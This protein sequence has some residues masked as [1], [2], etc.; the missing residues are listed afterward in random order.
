MKVRHFEVLWCHLDSRL[1]AVN[2][3]IVSP[4]IFSWL[5]MLWNVF[6]AKTI[7]ERINHNPFWSML[8]TLDG[9]VELL[10]PPSK[11]KSIYFKI[12]KIKM[13]PVNTYSSSFRSAALLGRCFQ[14]WTAYFDFC[15][16]YDK[17]MLSSSILTDTPTSV[18]ST[19]IY[20]P[21]WNFGAFS[22]L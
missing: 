20:F 5:K 4:L 13:K 3:S 18:F 17:S 21:D 7:T 9:A 14:Y 22:W 15:C 19:L 16:R 12:F 11:M 6:W 1:N 2:E 10:S 8:N